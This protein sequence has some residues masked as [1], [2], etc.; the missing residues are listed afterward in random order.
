MDQSAS[1]HQ[2]CFKF[3]PQLPYL[4]PTSASSEEDARYDVNTLHR[5]LYPE[6][7]EKSMWKAFFFFFF[8]ELL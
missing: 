4:Y 8:F 7:F 3:D 1:T 5:Q 2:Q 6:L